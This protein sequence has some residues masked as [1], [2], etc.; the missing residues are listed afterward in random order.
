M[1]LFSR[2][3]RFS[4]GDEIVIIKQV[5][6]SIFK[7]KFVVPKFSNLCVKYIM[8]LARTFKQLHIHPNKHKTCLNLMTSCRHFYLFLFKI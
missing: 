8:L 6:Q 5:L 3:R 4:L 7:N 1:I 2:G